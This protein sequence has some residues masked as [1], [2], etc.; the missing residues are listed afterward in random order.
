M[1]ALKTRSIGSLSRLG[2]NQLRQMVR[3][4]VHQVLREEIQTVCL[5]SQGT[6]IF[7]NEAEYA[8]YLDRQKG[9][10]PSEVNAIFIDEQG[11][12]VRYSDYVPTPKKARE[13]DKA[14]REPTVPAEVVWKEL[15]K[16]G[17]K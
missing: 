7:P 9:K 3:S 5:D 15:E 1:S 16:L 10:L 14:R 17:V 4:V 8:V 2:N 13:L 11:F 6:L 12:R